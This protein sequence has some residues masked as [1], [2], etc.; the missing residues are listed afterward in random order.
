MAWGAA[1]AVA[2]LLASG[3]TGSAAPVV[4]GS[5]IAVGDGP[6]SVAV[7]ETTNRVY[8]TNVG[9]GSVSVING[10][11]GGL[12]GSSIAVGSH[13]YGVAVNEATNRVYVTNLSSDSV[14]VIDGA[15]GAVVGSPIHVGDAPCGLA[16]NEATNR[17]YVANGGSDSVSVI[18]G[19]TGSV[20]ASLSVG[21]V[22]QG[23]AV[24]EV[25]NRVY[26]TNNYDHSVNVVNA[27]TGALVGGPIAV[28][29]Y[30]FAVAVN[31]ATNRV[32]VS[33]TDSDTV[34]VIDGVTGALIGAP[35]EVGD[36]P[37]GVAVN[38]VTNRIYV[39]NYSSG[40]VN[41]ID[42]VTGGVV[43]APIDVGDAPEG[44][45]V[46]EV[47]NRVY[48]ANYDDDTV[49]VVQDAPLVSGFT[50]S[51][52]PVGTSVTISGYGLSNATG[53]TFNGR[54]AT[55][56]VVD[57]AT[58]VT[59]KVPAG[60]TSGKIGVTTVAGTSTSAQSFTVVT[61]GSLVGTVTAGG[62]PVSGVRV[63]LLPGSRAGTTGSS[64]SYAIASV[65]AGTYTATFAKS[66]YRPV[67][68]NVTI[69][70]G[71]RTTASVTLDR[72]VTKASIARSPNKS[73]VTYKR[74]RGVARFGLSAVVKGWGGTA[75]ARRTVYLQSST[76]GKRWKSTYKLKT[77][78]KGKA[79]KSFK[80][81]TKRVRYYRW[82]VPAESQ[83]N[84]KT[85]SKRTKVTVK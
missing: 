5:P 80:T 11:T 21:H 8:V 25:T 66:G 54:A 46:N 20:I 28:G 79:T 55:S 22:P 71:K 61:T 35:I 24:N 51:S 27:A 30:P 17:V 49:S 85:Y 41:V 47:T 42:G 12:L 9:S 50:P 19:A 72:I 18:D 38:E 69:T 73:M 43:G 15:T 74:K 70:A 57:S 81:R 36:Y 58:Q 7:N 32:Y 37:E 29:S 3:T 14:S 13:P 56:F 16:V 78:S 63:T 65:A 2:L 76:N 64:G 77:N 33:N 10:A 6:Y 31:E 68:Q 67:T 34:S 39:T 53:V 48:V 1:I 40:F 52:G 82:Y 60:A 44:V 26:V 84:L 23:V 45:T 59:A 62:S 75:A 83:F 4:S